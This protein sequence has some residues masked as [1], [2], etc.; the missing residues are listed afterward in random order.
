MT[1]I[2]RINP[3]GVAAH[4]ERLS[5]SD[6]DKQLNL[7]QATGIHWVRQ[8]IQW[9]TVEPAQGNWTFAKHDDIVNGILSRGMEVIGL[10]S[11]YWSP[12]W[13]RGSAPWNQPPAPQDYATF[14]GAVAAHF[15]GKI[16]LYEVGN[17]PNQSMFWYPS[18]TAAAYSALLKPPYPPIKAADSAAKVISAGLSPAAP[19]TFLKAMYTAGVQGSM[20][21]VGY[22]PY[23]HPNGPDY[24]SSTPSFA[25]LT[26]I[27]EIMRSNGD[28]NKQIM[29]TEVG[30][31]THTSGVDEPTQAYYVRRVF[32]KIMHE[33]YPHLAIACV[34][35]F[36]DDGTH[37]ANATHNFALIRADYSEKPAYAAM[38]AARDDYDANFVTV[39]V[40]PSVTAQNITAFA[41]TAFSSQ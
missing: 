31:P 7:M 33:D 38:L 12:A 24:T 16:P 28:G 32:Q 30:R 11:Q 2:P 6:V 8:E 36:L 18:P 22:H 29:A 27:K 10:L 25:E 9:Q 4:L 34:Y 20:D 14:A 17:E 21:Y 39:V 23:S 5:T 41:A 19:E 3:I 37:K 26:A 35:D 15:K 40:G 1:K 13:Y